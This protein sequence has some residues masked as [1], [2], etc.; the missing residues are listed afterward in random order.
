MLGYSIFKFQSPHHYPFLLLLAFSSV[1]SRFKLKLPGLNGNMS[2][3][4]PFILIGA[5]R[6]SLFEGMLIALVSSAV[7]TMPKR[8]SQ[9]STVKLLFNVNTIGLAAGGCALLWHQDSPA[10]HNWSGSWPLILS[11]AA[12]FLINTL[13]VATIIS[14]TEGT[15]LTR[16][17]SSIFQLSFPY[18]LSCTG[19]LAIVSAIT[20]QVSWVTPMA[21]VPVMLLTYL[22]YRKYFVL[23]AA[24]GA[25]GTQGAAAVAH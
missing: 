14:L 23:S 17:W 24:A 3:N 6:L 20:Q 5:A 4:L 25:S 9:F 22:S 18:Y 2:V 13:P 15:K 10:S 7:Q 19:L 1:A 12:F 16:T 8:G 11:C 21:L